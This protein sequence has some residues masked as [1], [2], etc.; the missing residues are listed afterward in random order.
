MLI[1]TDR[2]HL[3]DMRTVYNLEVGGQRVLIHGVDC[4]HLG[5]DE[6]QD[7]ASL[8]RGSVRVSV[9]LDLDDS[10]FRELQFLGHLARLGLG[11]VQRLNQLHVVE[12]V[13]AGRRQL[14]Q[15][16]VFELFQQS[17]VHATTHNTQM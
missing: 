8:G 12:H 1:D 3:H 6:E 13:A 10:L 7:G 4:R 16:R 2:P 17:L 9:L 5:E 14:A 15:Q 11:V